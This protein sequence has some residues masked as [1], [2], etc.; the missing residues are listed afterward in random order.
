MLI[1]PAHQRE[2]LRQNTANLRRSRSR[3]STIFPH[4]PGYKPRGYAQRIDRYANIY[5]S[6]RDCF[7]LVYTGLDRSLC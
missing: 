1:K 4:L 6:P 5:Q 7:G 3:Y 2:R